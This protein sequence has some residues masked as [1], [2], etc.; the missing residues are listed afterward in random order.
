MKSKHMHRC[1]IAA[2]FALLIYLG[3]ASSRAEAYI[4]PGTGSSL[5]SS[6]GLILGLACTGVAVGFAQ[7]RRCSGWLFA[8]VFARRKGGPRPLTPDLATVK[9]QSGRRLR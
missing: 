1:L 3:P 7:L 2:A 4:D 9:R 6:L 5:F 8:R